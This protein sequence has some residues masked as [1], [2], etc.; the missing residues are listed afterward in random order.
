MN[1]SNQSFREDAIGDRVIH[2]H[3]PPESQVVAEV[4]VLESVTLV[5][6][7]GTPHSLS[8]LVPMPLTLKLTPIYLFSQRAG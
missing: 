8:V 3:S 4:A 1:R 5:R 2:P 6:H 7:V